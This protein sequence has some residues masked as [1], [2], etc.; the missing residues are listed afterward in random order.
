[1][2]KPDITLLTDRGTAI[3]PA[4]EN[5]YDRAFKKPCPVHIK[6]NLIQKGF[7]GKT[8]SNLYWKATNACSEYEFKSI[9]TEMTSSSNGKGAAM[10]AYLSE[11]D[12]DWQLYKAIERGNL[13]Y[14][15]NSDNLVESAFSWLLESRSYATASYLLEAIMNEN[16]KRNMKLYEEVKNNE[17]DF[18]LT[19]R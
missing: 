1:M 13:I 4:L 16:I 17:N 6:R 5:F 8:L 14:E 9:M 7:T 19:T 3:L 2:N 10:A 11:I 18:G 12:Q 15:M